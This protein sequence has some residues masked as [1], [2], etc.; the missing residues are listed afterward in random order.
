MEDLFCSVAPSLNHSAFRI[1]KLFL[2]KMMISKED[3]NCFCSVI[4][5]Q[6]EGRINGTNIEGRKTNYTKNGTELQ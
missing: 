4:A 1:N 6:E 5:M 3:I 2:R